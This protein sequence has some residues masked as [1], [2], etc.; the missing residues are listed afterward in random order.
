M[1]ATF[2]LLSLS[3]RFS[4]DLYQSYYDGY[5]LDTK[6]KWINTTSVPNLRVENNSSGPKA[7]AIYDFLNTT[8]AQSMLTFSLYDLTG[9]LIVQKVGD[10]VKIKNTLITSFE[11][12][13]FSVYMAN[14]ISVDG[15]MHYS[16][17]V[18]IG[19]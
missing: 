4:T 13:P 8:S 15:K 11:D 7:S 17:K 6:S 1:S 10:K 5:I 14:L 12:L 18:V 2:N 19:N 3:G 16:G 9:K